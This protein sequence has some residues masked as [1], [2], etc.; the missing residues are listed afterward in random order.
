MVELYDGL[1]A[2]SQNRWP[3]LNWDLMSVNQ[4]F[5]P[6]F[7]AGF[8][9]KT[10][11]WPAKFW[12]RLYEPVIRRAAGMGRLSGKIDPDSY[13]KAHH[14]CD[15][16]VIGGGTAGNQRRPGGRRGRCAGDAGGGACRSRWP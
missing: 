16:L 6:V 12:T 9:Y 4:L 1:V 5:A 10:F 13:E 7:V 15:I 3:S 8:Y 11:K 14:H 2:S